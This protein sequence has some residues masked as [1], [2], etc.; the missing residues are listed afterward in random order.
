MPKRTCDLD[1]IS[2]DE[3]RDQEDGKA[4]VTIRTTDGRGLVLCACPG[5]LR[6]IAG[7]LA[8]MAL[9]LEEKANE[10]RRRREDRARRN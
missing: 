7:Y 6:Q 9:G 4:T 5:C 8:G 3:W 10:R 2:V 1:R